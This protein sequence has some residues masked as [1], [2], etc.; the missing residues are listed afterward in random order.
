M[1]EDFD[2]EA[3]AA[4]SGGADAEITR[5]EAALERAA[6]RSGLADAPEPDRASQ[7]RPA[8]RET[9]SQPT[10]PAPP[11]EDRF[12][13][14]RE[15]WNAPERQWTSRHYRREEGRRRAEE[16]R[17]Q[18]ESQRL[19]QEKLDNLQSALTGKP[20][21]G[22][23]DFEL[24]QKDW[25]EKQLAALRTFV[26]EKFKP[27]EETFQQRRERE[28]QEQRQAQETEQ[29][30]E[31][32]QDRAQWAA[33]AEREWVGG[34]QR[35]GQE[36]AFYKRLVADTCYDQGRMLFGDGPQ[37][38]SFARSAMLSMMD[39]AERF[40]HNPAAL[41][42]GMG[43]MQMMTALRHAHAL[44]IIEM[45]GNGGAA[46]QPAPSPV[47]DAKEFIQSAEDGGASPPPVA[48]TTNGKAPREGDFTRWALNTLAQR[49]GKGGMPEVIRRG[50]EKYG[51]DWPG[52]YRDLQAQIRTLARG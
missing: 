43:R 37:A 21:E 45:A 24:D 12:S 50:K 16:Q 18:A 42:E 20:G 7:A 36:Y 13:K 4:E 52:V 48:R 5:A 38:E 1:A 49:G 10:P 6:T 30:A 40:N 31:W 32:A 46:R 28:A 47:S 11:W 14:S 33:E 2:F 8:A 22:E 25:F 9:S 44:G 23:P 35:R 51:A 29:F 3:P 39:M 26:E 17:I 41:V 27:L 15:A 19:L 34:D